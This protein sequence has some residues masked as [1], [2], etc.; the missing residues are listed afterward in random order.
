MQYLSA[1]LIWIELSS[2]QTARGL[3]RFTA[4]GLGMTAGALV[5]GLFWSV[6][7]LGGFLDSLTAHAPSERLAH[8]KKRNR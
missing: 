3:L 1:S 5:L 6:G 8:I 4:I 7:T 2:L